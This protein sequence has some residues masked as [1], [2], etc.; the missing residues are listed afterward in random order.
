MRYVLTFLKTTLLVSLF[1]FGSCLAG[2][3]PNSTEVIVDGIGVFP[4]SEQT[5]RS[6]VMT[7]PGKIEDDIRA[8]SGPDFFTFEYGEPCDFDKRDFVKDYGWCARGAYV[9]SDGKMIF[10]TG[11]KGFS[12][13][14]GGQAGTAVSGMPSNRFGAC[15]GAQQKDRFRLQMVI[16]QDQPS[17]EW[18]FHLEAAGTNKK[19]DDLTQFVIKGQ[20]EQTFAY[21][22]GFVRNLSTR[23]PLT[24]IRFECKTPGATIKIKS[25]RIAPSSANIYFRKKFTIAAAP[26]LAHATFQV[27]PV[28]DL[29][30]NG[31]KVDSGP[32]IYPSGMQKT[33][34]LRP[35][36]KTGENVIAFRNEFFSWFPGYRTDWLFE[37]VVVDRDGNI[38]RMLGDD[39]WKC[40]LVAENEWELPGFD[41]SAWKTP[42]LTQ[43]SNGMDRVETQ[44]ARGLNPRHMGMLDVS[45]AN[46]DYPV[47]DFT[48]VPVFVVRLPIGVKD[49]YSPLVE[50]FKAGTDELVETAKAEECA[51]ANGMAI[52]RVALQTRK[53]GPYR[54]IWKLV[55]AAGEIIENRREEMV[56]VGPIEQERIELAKFEE[57]LN[58]RLKLLRSIDCTGEVTDT[59]EFLDHSGMYNPAMLNKGRVVRDGELAYRETGGGCWDYFAYRIELKNHGAP[60]LIEVI[61]PDDR[62][63]YIYS[64]V[65]ELHPVRYGNNSARTAAF[66]STGSCLT[67]GRYPLSGKTSTIRYIHHPSSDTAAVLVMNGRRDSRAAAC[68]IN[69]Y[70]IEGGLPA[71][72]IP[73][74]ERRLGTHNE[75]LS[76]MARTLAC[77]NPT[78]NDYM[79]MRSGHRDAW[80][81]WYRAFER[82]I[83]LLR[84]QGRN[85]TV[86]GLFMYNKTDYPSI[87]NSWGV[88]NQEFDPAYLGLKMYEHN[89][90]HC[91]IG[92]E[93]MCNPAMVV[94]NVDTVSDRRMWQGEPV[95]QKV[96]RY[97]RQ[98]ASMSHAGVNFL[99][100]TVDKYYMDLLQEIRS[101]YGSVKSVEGLFTVVGNWYLPGFGMCGFNELMPIEIGYGDYTVTLF[102]RETGIRLNLAPTD[103]ERFAK[104]FEILTGNYKDAWITWRTNKVREFIERM[105]TRLRSGGQPWELHIYPTYKHQQLD[106]NTALQNPAANREAC[107]SALTDFLAESAFPLDR[108]L[109]NPFI[110]LICPLVTVGFKGRYSGERVLSHHAWNTNPGAL[111]AVRKIDSIYLNTALDEVDCPATAAPDWPWSGTTRGVFVARGNGDNFMSG[112]VDV[113]AQTTPRTIITQ[114]MDC[115]ME[116]GA[117]AQL[118]RFA[119]E[120]YVTPIADFSAL[121][122]TQTRGVTAQV[123]TRLAGGFFLRLVNNCP[124]RS[125]G[126]ISGAAK[127]HDLVYEVD[128]TVREAG[129]ITLL[130]NDIR[131]FIILD[132]NLAEL[133]CDFAL[134]PETTESLLAQG[135]LV[136]QH[137]EVFNSLPDDKAAQLRD[138]CEKKDAFRIYLAL[139]DFEVAA[140]IDGMLKKQ[141]ALKNQEKLLAD[142]KDKGEGCIDFAATSERNAPGGRRWLPDQAY[143]DANAYGNT[144]ATFVDRGNVAIENT[145]EDFVY[146]TEA[147]GREIVY[148]IPLPNE[149]YNVRLYVAETYQEVKKPG[150]RLFSIQ[151]QDHKWAEKLDPFDK[152]GGYAKALVLSEESV[153]V[154]D[155]ILTLKFNGGVGVH[156]VIIEKVR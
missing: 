118:R 3:A 97:G 145:E 51:E 151:V 134:S 119:L 99:H 149:T 33:I 71:L 10:T 16:E 55:D 92:L 88:S 137:A 69:I 109:N 138:A 41:D 156:G 150:Q 7:F 34:D 75:R 81:H 91:M 5:W 105:S 93:Y 101:H 58:A 78:E 115:N 64:G 61:I 12:F 52:F 53:T 11:K 102:E 122:E 76:V 63:R 20:G 45:L 140:C 154:S 89:G 59:R 125:T 144:G 74:T 24:G 6:K 103:P 148:R 136:M 143:L 107:T 2:E 128:L 1:S 130:P 28:Y 104:R 132:A 124:Y 57:K 50:I 18:V 133:R 47:F 39:S 87:R 83:R 40:G 147:Y 79:L 120:H 85:F 60:H 29:F 25:I 38:T 129:E 80:Y 127:V 94:A 68:K 82:K 95:M 8:W 86:E 19:K 72:K 73:E 21:D 9:I 111:A 146:Q 141:Q 106:M 98:L 22:L 27:S 153:R 113:L 90:I 112:F 114:W 17:T 31:Q 100:P 126:T 152:A 37:G 48:E 155:G 121:P 30:I 54:L 139:D 13:G 117:S 56:V 131:T 135:L 46:K 49:K 70:S 32:G 15:W 77:E 84:Y 116:T 66:S 108:Y 42:R 35:Y 110:R 123:A 44:V 65:L 14:F 62:E 142:I 23:V 96:D 26:V 43:Y 67:G 36:L 4:L